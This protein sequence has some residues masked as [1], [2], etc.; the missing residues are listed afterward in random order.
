MGAWLSKVGSGQFKSPLGVKV[1]GRLLKVGE[2][3]TPAQ[4]CDKGV[5]CSCSNEQ[6]LRAM[7]S[8]MVPHAATRT[9]VKGGPVGPALNRRKRKQSRTSVQ[10]VQSSL[11]I[12]TASAC[13]GGTLGGWKT[14]FEHSNTH[15]SFKGELN[16]CT[17]FWEATQ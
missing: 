17:A 11:K 8:S 2:Y 4:S 15:V 16:T 1:L 14:C 10:C 12:T 6:P 13:C 7:R 5:P 3:F 9:T